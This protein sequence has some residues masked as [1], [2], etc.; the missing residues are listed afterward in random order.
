MIIAGPVSDISP[1]LVGSCEIYAAAVGL[2]DT[3]STQRP[4]RQHQWEAVVLSVLVMT[5][6]R[7]N[8]MRRHKQQEQAASA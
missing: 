2:T 4:G 8:I 7:M 3:C 1:E 5:L 6:G